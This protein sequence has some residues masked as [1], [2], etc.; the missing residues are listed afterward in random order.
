MQTFESSAARKKQ[1]WFLSGCFALILLVGVIGYT[2]EPHKHSGEWIVFGAFFLVFGAFFALTVR[3]IGIETWALYTLDEQSVKKTTW[4]GTEEARWDEIT[5]YEVRSEEGKPVY[6]LR[7]A[8]GSP[9]TIHLVYVGDRASEMN[10]LLLLRLE[11]VTQRMRGRI[12]KEVTTL[13]PHRK[14][15]CPL[16]IACGVFSLLIPLLPSSPSRHPEADRI[17]LVLMQLFGIAGMV[18]AYWFYRWKI[19]IDGQGVAIEAPFISKRIEF[20]DIT[21]IEV[22]KPGYTIRS[23]KTAIT[24]PREA[25]E[26][27]FL[28]SY[29]SDRSMPIMPPKDPA[30][31]K[32]RGS[33]NL[34]LGFVFLILLCIASSI[35]F[36][37]VTALQ[38]ERLLDRQSQPV[39][40]RITQL[41]QNRVYYS[42]TAL[43]VEYEGESSIV[44][45]EAKA[46][47]IGN[48]IRVEYLPD[49]PQVSRATISNRRGRAIGMLLIVAINSVV[50]AALIASKFKK[51]PTKS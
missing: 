32:T 35:G 26:S 10:A 20:R 39:N 2:S 23:L 24:L 44:P 5:V 17:A 27:H 14:I 37:G 49:N 41:A 4:L 7:R 3:Y 18:G 13:Y 22:H 40:G 19:Q 9:L 1:F 15:T 50:F 51:K 42:F 29:I 12:E 11:P 6:R 28:A 30:K 38:T 33:N 36:M 45:K 43:N 31:L 48:P 34:Q 47:Q 8:E 21:A 16:S 25:Q 46:L